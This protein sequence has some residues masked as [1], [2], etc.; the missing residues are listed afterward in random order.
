MKIPGVIERESNRRLLESYQNLIFINRNRD[1][2]IA[3]DQ[4]EGAKH[5]NYSG[6]SYEA[7]LTR[8]Y[9]IYA[10]LAR[11]VFTYPK[12]FKD[13]NLPALIN[14]SEYW[15]RVGDSFKKFIQKVWSP[16]RPP[17]A[18]DPSFFLA[19]DLEKLLDINLLQA[20]YLETYEAIELRLDFF[21][22]RRKDL[23]YAEILELLREAIS[24][25]HLLVKAPLIMTIR[26][27]AE[28]GVFTGDRK[29]Y[30]KFYKDLSKDLVF[31]YYD[32]E[33]SEQNLQFIEYFVSK[34]K[35]IAYV[36]LSKHYFDYK[37]DKEVL[38][39]LDAMTSV[40][41][42][43]IYKIVL[44][45]QNDINILDQLHIKKPLIKFKLGA[46]GNFHLRRYFV[47]EKTSC[48]N[49]GKESRVKCQFFCPVYDELFDKPVAPGQLT[50]DEILSK[51]ETLR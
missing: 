5:P 4:R 51:I 1:D 13:S 41:A 47:K 23:P 12:Y 34:V 15:T 26:T 49:L 36:T 28:G 50:R 35:G 48:A 30:N 43:D 7:T 2:L 33:Y 38:K 46:K 24:F 45:E 10:S 27:K 18:T 8:R 14:E 11:Y 39:E 31:T 3:T 44:N 32:I 22:E 40:T 29:L 20:R 17:L 6:A 9:P 25:V 19:I 16:E 37:N 42:V 21:I